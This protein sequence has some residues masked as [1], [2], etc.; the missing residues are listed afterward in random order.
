M[1]MR[2]LALADEMYLTDKYSSVNTAV[3][4]WPAGTAEWRYRPRQP[5]L[6][7]FYDNLMKFADEIVRH[8][9]KHL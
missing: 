8:R 6:Q 4:N 5:A 3:T 2:R 1:M 7:C 9:K